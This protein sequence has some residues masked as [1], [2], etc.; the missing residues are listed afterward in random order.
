MPAPARWT[1]N[2]HDRPPRQVVDGAEAD[3]RAKDRALANEERTDRFPLEN[4]SQRS[5]NAR[6]ETVVGLRLSAD[7]QPLDARGANVR[8]KRFEPLLDLPILCDDCG[9]EDRSQRCSRDGDS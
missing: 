6:I 1:T 7:A 5:L 4:L 8:R 2:T 9:A 3:E